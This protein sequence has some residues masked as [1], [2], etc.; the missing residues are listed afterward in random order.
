MEILEAV[1]FID[2]EAKKSFNR[3]W[4]SKFNDL[5]LNKDIYVASQDKNSY[6]RLRRIV[7]KVY[8]GAKTGGLF[9]LTKDAHDISYNY[10][11]TD[12]KDYGSK[13]PH[14]ECETED[15]HFQ[16]MSL[17]EAYLH[18]YNEQAKISNRRNRGEEGRVIRAKRTADAVLNSP[19]CEELKIWLAD[20]ITSIYFKLPICS[21]PVEMVLDDTLEP[22]EFEKIA[23]KWQYAAD[24][25]LALWKPE[26]I[27][28]K[29]FD[30]RD[31]VTEPETT[32][33]W[34]KRR[35]PNCTI[36][37]DCDLANSEIPDEINEMILLAKQE[38]ADAGVDRVINYDIQG[39]KLDSYYF[40]RAL[41]EIFNYDINF[42]KNK[43][44]KTDIA[45]EVD[46]PFDQDFDSYNVYGEK[47]ESLKEGKEDKYT[48]C[49]CGEECYGYGNNPEPFKHEG[50]CCDACNLHYV[51]PARLAQLNNKEEE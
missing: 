14:L 35:G 23:E 29:D 33:I 20:H 22:E 32:S 41:G 51:I 1:E 39:N 24:K 7:E 48:C 34:Y 36:I 37:F 42:Y 38:S 8:I 45:P 6:N 46:N 26:L 2:V 27:E 21:D 19:R 30:Y 40:G 47:V 9:I 15:L 25:F 12:F 3:I 4:K 13:K 5:L 44:K 18:E 11:I 10:N 43:A 28:G 16:L 50:R 17:L 31:A 49:I